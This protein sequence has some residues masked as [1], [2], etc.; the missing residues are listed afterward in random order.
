M[1]DGVRVSILH[2]NCLFRECLA[3]VLAET[4]TVQARHADLESGD[5]NLQFEEHRP[6]LILAEMVL[7][8]DVTAKRLQE[9]R[10]MVAGVKIAVLVPAQV[11]DAIVGCIQVGADGCVLDEAS[12]DE[13]KT[14]IETVSCGQSYCSPQIANSMFA[15]LGRLARENRWSRRAEVVK[16]TDRELEI[17][18]LIADERLS[19]K[20]IAL[21]LKVSL[22]TVKNHVHNIIEKL[23]VDNRFQA[24]EYAYEQ[25][26][27]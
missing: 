14:M 10:Q 11:E 2:R 16:L 9:L 1:P 26:M 6:D 20:Q 4:E 18:R 8:A 22:Y 15:E 23:Q 24:A 21:K 13:L 27:L 25:N 19:N 3:A 7:P 5:L 17:L 12:I